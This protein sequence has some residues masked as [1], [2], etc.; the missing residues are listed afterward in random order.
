[1]QVKYKER[2]GRQCKAQDRQFTLS[3]LFC[4]QCTRT[5]RVREV[6]VN[7]KGELQLS[8]AAALQN[9]ENDMTA[10]I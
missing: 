7:A 1:M 3:K 10:E 4:R 2:Q 5:T 9:G 6:G 8:P